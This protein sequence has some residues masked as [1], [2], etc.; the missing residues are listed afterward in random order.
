[1]N[2]GLLYAVATGAVVGAL[3][4]IDPIFIPLVLLGPLFTGALAGWRGW[5]LLRWVALAWALGG[6]VMTVSDW[7]VNEEDVAFHLALTVVMPAL[8]AVAWYAG[9]FA[10][11]RRG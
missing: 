5:P 10:G 6:L 2:R 1:M 11:R 4:W 3:A 7:I 9:R 8:A